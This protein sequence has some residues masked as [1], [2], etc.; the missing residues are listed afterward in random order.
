MHEYPKPVLP[1]VVIGSLLGSRRNH[2][3]RSGVLGRGMDELVR[4]YETDSPKLLTALKQHLSSGSDEVLVEIRLKAGTRIDDVLPQ[5]KAEGF[6]LQATSRIGARLIEGYMPIWS[7]R[8]AV[9]KADV[10]LARGIDGTGIRL[11]ALPTRPTRPTRVAGCC[12][13]STTSHREQRWASPVGSTAR[14][15]SRTTSS[16]CATSS[17]RT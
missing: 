2:S 11:G 9:E 13:W 15:R 12:N 6:R 17:T 3:R 16:R 7:A 5:L 8:V 4:L 14:S 1:V 10:V